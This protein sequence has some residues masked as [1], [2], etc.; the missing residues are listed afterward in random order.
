MTAASAPGKPL[1]E[2][3]DLRK[4]FEITEGVWPFVRKKYVRAVDGVSFDVPE[5]SVVAIVGESG[6]GKTT[7][8]RTIVGIYKPTSGKILFMGKDLAGMTWRERRKY[9][10]YM[11]MVF[12]SPWSSLNPRMRVF[13]IIYEALKAFN[14]DL[15]RKEAEEKVYELLRLV[16]LPLEIAER[17]PVELSGGQAQRVAIARAIAPKPKLLVLDEPTSALDVSVQ[18]KIIE[19]LAELKEKLGLTYLLISHDLGVVRY[20]SDYVQVMYMGVVV[21]SGRTED[22]ILEPMHPY[23]KMLV[24]A[25]P[26]PDPEKKL[27]WKKLV[28]GEPPSLMDPPQGCRFNT[29]CPYAKDKCFKEQ[30]PLID[31]DGRRVACWLYAS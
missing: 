5:G 23:T 25:V 15:S 24:A 12:Q 2:V 1:L 11:Q 3:K 28:V 30:P 16:E 19:L 27:E 22:V 4:Y 17:Y 14:K 21:E 10:R 7:L 8:A 26:E 18:A 6:S 31:V 29:R 13:N 9:A 20:I